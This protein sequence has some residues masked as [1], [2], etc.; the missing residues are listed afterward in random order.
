MNE[1]EIGNSQIFM[2][3]LTQSLS[4]KGKMYMKAIF[5]LTL[6][7]TCS[8]DE[9]H[10]GKHANFYL[11]G[12]FFFDVHPPLAKVIMCKL[13][14]TYSFCSWDETHFGKHANW[15]LKGE[16]FFDVHPPLAKVNSQKVALQ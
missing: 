5:V 10:F 6:L 2:L 14:C 3:N 8:W 4:L 7:C 9:T 11:K 12:E 1:K 16:F 15:Y 13:C